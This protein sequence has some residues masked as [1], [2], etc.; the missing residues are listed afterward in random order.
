MWMKLL[1]SSKLNQYTFCD[2]KCQNQSKYCN[3]INFFYNLKLIYQNKKLLKVEPNR[4]I[5]FK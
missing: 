1:G 5:N 4:I 2:F 3:L